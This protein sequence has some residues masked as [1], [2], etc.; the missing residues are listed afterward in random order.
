MKFAIE[1]G[2]PADLSGFATP[3]RQL[4]LHHT[5]PFPKDGHWRC[6]CRSTE[7]TWPPFWHF[8]PS[9]A[10]WL[11]QSLHPESASICAI[12]LDT[13]IYTYIIMGNKAHED[14]STSINPVFDDLSSNTHFPIEAWQLDSKPRATP[15]WCAVWC[16]CPPT[17]P[18][19]GTLSGLD[20]NM[21]SQKH[22]YYTRCFVYTH[23]SW[24]YINIRHHCHKANTV[25]NK[26][27]KDFLSKKMETGLLLLRNKQTMANTCIFCA[28]HVLGVLPFWSVLRMT[29]ML[30]WVCS[31]SLGKEVLQ[32]TKSENLI[33]NW[34]EWRWRGRWR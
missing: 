3:L 26:L 25:P 33:R 22:V 31:A 19:A 24:V 20:A 8:E 9:T 21:Y 30:T 23:G 28:P 5:L 2:S 11:W 27:A 17:R 13:Y 32:V 10:L 7:S 6:P 16:F 4:G 34:A 12:Y 15:H 18:A 14:P 1:H 29:H